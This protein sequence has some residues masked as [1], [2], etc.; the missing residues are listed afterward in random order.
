MDYCV[1]R[2]KTHLI[3]IATPYRPLRLRSLKREIALMWILIM[4]RH[5]FDEMESS[6]FGTKNLIRHVITLKDAVCNIWE[7]YSKKDAAILQRRKF[8]SGLHR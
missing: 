3:E 5:W 4:H 1:I 6:L 2:C 8:P 7:A